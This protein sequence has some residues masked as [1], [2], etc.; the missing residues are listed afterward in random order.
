MWGFMNTAKNPKPITKAKELAAASTIYGQANKT[1]KAG[2][3]H[4]WKPPM[5]PDR[6]G[7]QEGQ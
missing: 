3:P 5:R 1:R 4:N 2:M 6:G 7:N